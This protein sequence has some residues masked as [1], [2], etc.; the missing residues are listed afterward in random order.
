[1]ANASKNASG[2]PA[3][4]RDAAPAMA[5]RYGPPF[6]VYTFSGSPFLRTSS[7]FGSSWCHSSDPFVPSISMDRPFSRPWLIC[8]A[9]TVPKAPLA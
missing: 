8:D 6:R 4:S 2:W 7:S 1:M 9:V 5:P 3:G